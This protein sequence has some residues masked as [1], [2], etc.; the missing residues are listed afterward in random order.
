MD[1]DTWGLVA[2][3][4]AVFAACVVLGVWFVRVRRVRDAAPETWDASLRRAALQSAAFMGV[5]A[6]ILFGAMFFSIR[7][8]DPTSSLLSELAAWSVAGCA[9]F[10]VSIY[11]VLVYSAGLFMERWKDGYKW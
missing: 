1:T 8:E 3:T 2:G 5:V 4:V 9:L 6:A 10:A 11:G 7:A